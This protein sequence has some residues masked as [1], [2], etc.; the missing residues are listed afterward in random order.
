MTLLK[1]VLA[2]LPIHIF[3]CMV[4][5]KQVQK[6]IDGLMG[7]FL[8]SQKG[9]HRTHWVSWQKICQPISEGGL[10]IRSVSEAIFGLH[11]K[12]AWKILAQHSLW[13]RML[14]QKYGT[15]SVYEATNLRANSSPLWRTVFP[16]LQ[17][18]LS[19]SHWQL[20]RGDISF[21]CS[22]WSGEVLQPS[23]N[24]D[25]TVKQGLQNLH[26]VAHL[27]TYE[28]LEDFGL[29]ELDPEEDDKLIFEHT[30]TGKFSVGTYIAA[31]REGGPAVE[32]ARLVWNRLTPYR[33]NA[34][35]WRVFRNA[36]AVDSNIQKR[37]IALASKC[38]CCASPSDESLQ[39][40]LIHSEIA[41]QFRVFFVRSIHLLIN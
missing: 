40:I 33:I 38:V 2:S 6:R 24:A 34:F 37:G 32:W 20:G 25:V 21:W 28:Q 35:M 1:S 23:F 31:S 39:H 7:T 10:G 13:T 5:P 30:P 19:M 16:H 3:S 36:L 41:V 17:R 18:I 14:L 26:Q 9:N 4:V 27:F 12:L 29:I 15:K 22:N 8:W 11:G